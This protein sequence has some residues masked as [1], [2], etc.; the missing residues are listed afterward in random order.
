MLTQK[1]YE[2]Q[3]RH[4]TRQMLNALWRFEQSDESRDSLPLDVSFTYHFQMS[5]EYLDKCY[6]L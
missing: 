6:F 1:L 5:I 3:R 4:Y 2:V